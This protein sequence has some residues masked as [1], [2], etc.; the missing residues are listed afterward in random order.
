M[1]ASRFRNSCVDNVTEAVLLLVRS[2]IFNRTLSLHADI[3]AAR[4]ITILE[5]IDLKL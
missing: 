3:C 1:T 4:I 5:S 2:T